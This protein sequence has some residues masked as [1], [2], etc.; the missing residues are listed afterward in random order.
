MGG[1]EER[2]VG[3]E[4]DGYY[5]HCQLR[6]GNGSGAGVVD[7][8]GVELFLLRLGQSSSEPSKPKQACHL[9]SL[10]NCTISSLWGYDAETGEK[11]FV[12]RVCRERRPVSKE[13][14]SMKAKIG[15]SSSGHHGWA[16][17]LSS[18]YLQISCASTL[19]LTIG[20]VTLVLHS[21]S[22]FQLLQTSRARNTGAFFVVLAPGMFVQGHFRLCNSM[23]R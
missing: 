3:V 19:Q 18:V 20:I 9:V 17:G 6:V 12:L 16:R 4:D 15:C 10:N 5:G 21:D 8:A 2:R 22:D 23:S 7:H 11:Q 1:V 13:Y 14:R